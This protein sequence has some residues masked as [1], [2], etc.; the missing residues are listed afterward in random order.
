MF[1]V[2]LQHFIKES[3][4]LKIPDAQLEKDL[5]ANGWDKELV[6]QAMQNPEKKEILIHVQDVTKV[7]QPSKTLTVPAIQGIASLDIYKG[8]FVAIT[9]QSGSGKS[10]LLNLLGLVDEP[11]TG[12]IWIGEQ[13]TNLLSERQ[14]A[15]LRLKVISFIFQFFNLLENYSA[16]ENIIFQSRLQGL[17]HSEAKKKAV[18][19]LSFLGMEN[20]ATLYPSELSG[21]QQQRIAIGRAL[22]KDSEII[23]ADEP[24]AHLDSKNSEKIIGLLREINYKFG[25]TIILVTHEPEYAALA[26]RTINIVDGRIADATGGAPKQIDWSKFFDKK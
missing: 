21:G 4:A 20:K 7:Y 2:R 19:I 22:A 24:T 25:K 11:T 6:R 12:E 18:D 1:D 13:N 3:R 26:D 17:S 5:V 23:L 9:G 14:K 10:T 15:R 16:L 8:E